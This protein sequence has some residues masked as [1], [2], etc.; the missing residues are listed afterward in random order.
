MVNVDDGGDGVRLD[1]W[2]DVAENELQHINHLLPSL[3]WDGG[4]LG[5]RMRLEPDDVAELCKDYLAAVKAAVAK[6]ARG[7]MAAVLAV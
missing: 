3:E 7:M 2:L 5:V 4:A 6:R 1:V